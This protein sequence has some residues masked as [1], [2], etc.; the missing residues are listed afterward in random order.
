M[1][2]TFALK[3]HSKNKN[4][5]NA[6]QRSL[7]ECKIPQTNCESSEVNCVFRLSL[8]FSTEIMEFETKQA[9]KNF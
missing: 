5:L 9:Y 6:Q 4:S 8:R 7:H 3:R 2:S 1:C